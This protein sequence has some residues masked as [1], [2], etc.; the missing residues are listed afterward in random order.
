MLFSIKT[1]KVIIKY[2]VGTNS[3]NLPVRWAA[4]RQQRLV[5]VLILHVT[6]DTGKCP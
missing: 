2:D 1:L 6:L 3:L 4:V 5:P